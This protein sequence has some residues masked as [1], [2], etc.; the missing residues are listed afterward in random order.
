MVDTIKFSQMPS[1]GNINNN[2]IMPSLR[3]GANVLL[4]NPWTFLPPGSTADRPAPSS[5]I[6]YRLRFNTDQQLYE[7]YDAILGAW[8]QLQESAFTQGPFVIYKADAS[9]PDGQNL[10]AL[11]NGILRQTI[12]TGVATLDIAVNGT[13]YYGPGFV[14]PGVSGGTGV[15]N[16]A[17]TITLSGGATGYVLTSDSS[18]NAAWQPIT[19]EGA[20]TTIDGDSGSITPTVGVVT[21]NGGST[22]LTTSGS[23]STLSLGGLL[24][25][26]FGGL[27]V[28]NPTAH[29]ILI[30][31]GSSPVTPIVLT[32]GQILI[33]STG[34][35]PVAAAIGSGTG[36]L[37]GNGP[38]SITVSLAAIADQRILA[39]ISGGSAAPTANSLTAI[40]DAC[41][42]ST[43]GDLLYRNASGWVVLAPGTSGQ[44][45]QTQGAAANPQWVTSATVTP[46]AL[47]KTDDTNVTLTLGGTPATALLQ[48][49]SLTLGWTGTLAPTRGGTGIGT[50]T[51][52]DTLYSSGTN[53]LSKLAGNTTTTKQYLSQT[54]DGVN[55]AAPV[56]A[57]ISGSDITGA[58]LTKT[59]DTNVTLTLGGTPTTA[60]LRAASLTLGWT[61]Q[62]SVP[63]GGTGLA[64]ATA[65]AVLCGGTT[66]TGP[67]Q[68][69]AS[70]GTTGQVLTSNGPGAL[71]TFQN[72]AG[73]GTVN[74]G[75]INQ[76]AWYAANGTAV[77]GLA[78][79]NNG[80]LVT[81]AG[82]VPSIS[83]TLPS[84]IAATGMLLTTPHITTGL[85][86][87]NGANWIAQIATA[88]A[89][90]YI[91]IANQSTTNSP[92]IGATGSDSNIA[93]V[94]NGKG[95][96]GAQI[97]GRTNGSSPDTGYAGE[98]LE[99]VVS[100]GAPVA[101][102]NN[103]N[104]NVTSLSLSAGNWMVFGNISY[105]NPTGT[106]SFAIGW[107]STTSATG[108]DASLFV[109]TTS[110]LTNGNDGFTV[111]TRYFKSSSSFTAY[112]S[113][114]S[115][116]TGNLSACG[117]LY[118]IRMP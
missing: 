4:N 81:S 44:F 104:A 95:T 113:T 42:G 5:T 46:A 41:I 16:G 45:L 58:A 55:S 82:G 73:T 57:T 37:V 43:Q 111:P 36:I 88:S 60:L 77:S 70:V 6:N 110:I 7:Y 34:A 109:Q 118:A 2:D 79:A 15:N 78:T 59:D 19:A 26:T 83:S 35:D 50:Y 72:V 33:G 116:F 61:G 84:G 76:L 87:T 9:I 39:N 32:S 29:G 75:S 115:G 80:V 56:W 51:L 101:L 103:T 48:A 27:G 98:E 71:P 96:L 31:E 69:I 22:G 30:G 99:S 90:N 49:T 105:V 25:S 8:T 94:L 38:G 24:N 18:G 100:S 93:L 14:I 52:G 12:T 17:L 28:S 63:R 108:V 53:I 13:D 86:D 112:L 23:G 20:I 54:G 66:S 92:S 114:I 97:Q 62:L 106:N 68:S 40:I 11:S 65:Y 1:A 89:V 64:S 74:S 47:T 67:F 21:I 91:T 117:G 107:I 10:G 102:T 3:S 85:L